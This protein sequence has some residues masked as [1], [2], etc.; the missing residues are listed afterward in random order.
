MLTYITRHELVAFN[1]QLTE[2]IAATH[3]NETGQAARDLSQLAYYLGFK[4][5]TRR[6]GA[7]I[8]EYYRA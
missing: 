4:F 1:R 5:A 6:P 3:G 7:R 2:A 8:R